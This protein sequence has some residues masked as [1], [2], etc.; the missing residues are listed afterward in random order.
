MDRITE[1]Q[2]R[3]VIYGVDEFITVVT[4]I[5]ALGGSAGSQQQILT[6]GTVTTTTNGDTNNTTVEKA[7]LKVEDLDKGGEAPTK[8]QAVAITDIVDQYL[9]HKQMMARYRSRGK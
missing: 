5:D 6:P 2:Y 1:D 8:Y 3:D 4:A 9:K 7:T